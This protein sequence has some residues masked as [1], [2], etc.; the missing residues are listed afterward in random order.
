MPRKTVRALER[1]KQNKVEGED[2]EINKLKRALADKIVIAYKDF[3][4]THPHITQK[5]PGIKVS[6]DVAIQVVK[7]FE[8][9]MQE[10][11]NGKVHGDGTLTFRKRLNTK[12]ENMF[13]KE[14]DTED[15]GMPSISRG[16]GVPGVLK[17]QYRP[18]LSRKSRNRQTLI[19]GSLCRINKEEDPDDWDWI[20]IGTKMKD[21]YELQRDD[22]VELTK[23][24][25]DED[26][27]EDESDPDEDERVMSSL[28]RDWPFLFYSVPM[29]THYKRLTG[30][31]LQERVLKFL[32][33]DELKYL[34]LYYCSCSNSSAIN[35]QNLVLK[36]KVQ[37]EMPASASMST[38]TQFLLALCMTAN[39]F[40][41]TYTNT[42]LFTSEKTL[43]P[44]EVD[45]VPNLP[46]SI[47][48]IALGD[49]PFNANTYYVS[50]DKI[51]VAEKENALDAVM[52]L[53]KICFVFDIEY[54]PGLSLTFE[55]IE[56]IVLELT[57]KETRV[58]N[59]SGKLL[60][61][62][63]EKV[64]KAGKTFHNFKKSVREG[65]EQ[66]F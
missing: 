34:L 63:T 59:K 9:A 23:K 62:L 22:I 41:E 21:T 52:M 8:I 43:R 14:E 20:D 61:V 48:I 10:S 28:K 7:K 54:P 42:F 64:K 37:Q 47:C 33:A 38:S 46:S 4:K 6:F 11:L 15:G 53:I 60:L 44:E 25:M 45:S 18:P 55:F 51:C 50:L 30:I 58:K 27:G 35:T 19:R 40:A 13:R 12:I 65:L 39:N 29:N 56:R 2:D 17:D 57:V 36:L 16:V 3:R 24:V 66:D 31:D 32:S 1:A 5:T 26:K 49:D